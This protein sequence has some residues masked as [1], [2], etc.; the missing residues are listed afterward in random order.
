MT[1]R[2]TAILA[3]AA[4][5]VGTGVV[6]LTGDAPLHIQTFT[7]AWNVVYT[8]SN[9]APT[10]TGL[11]QFDTPIAKPIIVTS[12]VVTAYGAFTNTVSVTNKPYC[13][14]RAYVR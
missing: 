13:F 12:N 6:L 3:A 2:T 11:A 8:P 4:L 1:K 7:Y 10:V 9:S 5:T 14:W